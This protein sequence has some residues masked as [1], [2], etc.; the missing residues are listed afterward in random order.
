MEIIDY[1]D[2]YAKL[3]LKNALSRYISDK[4]LN[5]LVFL[6]IGTDRST[7]DSLGP[8][9]GYELTLFPHICKEC[10]IYGTLENPVHA[11]NIKEITS[12]IFKTMDNPFVIAIDAS[13]GSVSNVG[14]IIIDEGPLKPGAGVNKNL[15]PVGDLRITGVVNVSGFMEFSVLQNT[16]LSMVMNMAKVISSAIWITLLS[17]KQ[18]PARGQLLYGTSNHST[19][20]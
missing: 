7:G 15:D 2:R 14:K 1:K 11:Q 19:G 3:I 16:R 20:S 10:R 8:L 6:C 9:I 17:I 13:L 12:M 18:K 4:N 5:D